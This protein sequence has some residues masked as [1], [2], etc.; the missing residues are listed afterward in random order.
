MACVQ[1][2]K[3]INKR[4]HVIDTDLPTV[5]LALHQDYEFHA[6]KL[7]LKGYVNFMVLSGFAGVVL[8]M[9]RI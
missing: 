7:N 8:F 5:I 9:E 4:H 1:L 3:T 2:L 6:S